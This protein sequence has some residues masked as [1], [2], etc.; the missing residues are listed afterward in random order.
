[1]TSQPHTQ[2]IHG[3]PRPLARALEGYAARLDVD[4]IRRAHDLAVSAHEGQTR[5][6]G[7]EY[8]SHTIEVATIL[9]Q[10]RLD[11]DTIVAGLI[12]DVIEDTA[13]TAE[14]IVLLH[15]SIGSV[16]SATS[17]PRSPRSSTG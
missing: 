17:D 6:S 4:A 3:L 1:M 11:T 8:V 16:V 5:A 9:A 10:L 2:T 15:L 14:D 7:E 13:A 12:H